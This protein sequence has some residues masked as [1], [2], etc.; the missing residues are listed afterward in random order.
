MRARSSP[1]NQ[2]P[3]PIQPPPIRQAAIAAPP[4]PPPPL[5]RKQSVENVAELLVALSDP[6]AE[7]IANMS[8]PKNADYEDIDDLLKVCF[9]ILIG[10]LKLRGELYEEEK[11]PGKKS[12][13]DN[14]IQ[15]VRSEYTIAST[16]D[17]AKK[18]ATAEQFK[19][20]AYQIKHYYEIKLRNQV[21]QS[22]QDD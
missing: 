18:R 11:Q 3:P 17:E 13:N 21:P 6:L 16:G 9:D 1:P 8:I 19:S 4:P 22:E 5:E 12:R 10:I 20:R 7:K 14:I 15:H 2:P